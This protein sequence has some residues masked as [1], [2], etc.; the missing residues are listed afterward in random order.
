MQTSPLVIKNSSFGIIAWYNFRFNIFSGWWDH[1]T[2]TH[3]FQRKR[4]PSN[5]SIPGWTIHH[6][7]SLHYAA[8]ARSAEPED[9]PPKR[10]SQLRILNMHSRLNTFALETAYRQI[11]MSHPLGEG[12][13][14]LVVRNYLETNMLEKQSFMT[15]QVALFN[16]YIRSHEK[17]PIP[18][19]RR[20][21][22]RG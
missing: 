10:R 5:V 13:Q 14:I 19:P 2:N 16:A 7:V 4:K 3:L 12:F 1:V 6:H 11:K 18:L 17:Q 22:S 21:F 9:D 15:T 8:S 20:T